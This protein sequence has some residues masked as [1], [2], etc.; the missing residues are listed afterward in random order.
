[1][2][3][4]VSLKQSEPAAGT[5]AIQDGSTRQ[6][7]G[8]EAPQI[9]SVLPILPVRNLVVFPGT[10][11]PLTIGRPE[12]IKL[13]E[14]SLPQSRMIGVVAQRSPET[15]KP[16]PD[17][18]HRVGTAC[19]VLKLVRQSSEAVLL[20]V[21]AIQRFAIRKVIQTDRISAQRSI[22]SPPCCRRR[23]RNGR[24]R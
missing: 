15:D 3:S 9:P 19:A 7:K 6:I 12:S 2:S 8:T 1:M 20:V 13:L 14:E 17:E 10:V 22:P 11:L 18:L 23:A 24:P 21:N 4:E 5:E 16:T